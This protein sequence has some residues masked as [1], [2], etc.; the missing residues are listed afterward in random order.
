MKVDFNSLTHLCVKSL[1][2]CPSF[3]HFEN[4]ATET[5]L[6]NS[7]LAIINYWSDAVDV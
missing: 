7:K 2:H 5:L 4:S 1:N 6:V 3:C